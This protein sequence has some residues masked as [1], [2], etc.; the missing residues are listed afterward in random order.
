MA[1]VRRSFAMRPGAAEDREQDREADLLVQEVAEEAPVDRQDAARL[2]EARHDV[3][4][5]HAHDERQERT[6]TSRPRNARFASTSR[7]ASRVIGQ[8]R[9]LAQRRARLVAPVALVVDRHQSWISWPR[10]RRNTSSRRLGAGPQVAHLHPALA[11]RAE[12]QS[13]A[14]G[15]RAGTDATAV[16]ALAPL[17]A[18]VLEV[19]EEG[20]GVALDAHVEDLRAARPSA[21][22][23]CPGAA[24]WPWLSTI[25]LV[26]DAL[27]VAQQVRAEDE[28][29]LPRRVATSRMSASISS[30]PCGSRPFVGS[31]RSS[32]SG[33]WTRA[34]A[35]FTR[36]F[37]PVE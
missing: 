14:P 24:T 19:G 20:R 35:S 28:A 8:K 15:P 32:R 21:R 37:M 3:D 11:R 17:A 25:T 31:S 6:A 12:E 7:S 23:S 30:R 2:G 29:H 1:P 18:H 9:D 36:C 10:A 34:W 26:A 16:L 27:D 13:P 33:S 5:D 4:L 22:R